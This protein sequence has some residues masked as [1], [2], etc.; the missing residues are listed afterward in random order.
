M[1]WLAILLAAVGS[2]S[3]ATLERE[4]AVTVACSNW[5]SGREPDSPAVHIV[6]DDGIC[7]YGSTSDANSSAFVD[8]VGG[9]DSDRPLVVVVRSS[10]GE[11]IAALAMAEAMVERT[12]TVVVQRSCFSSCA[13]Y[14]FLA[15]DRRVVM[16]EAL[17]GYHGGLYAPPEEYWTQTRA[18]F[19]TRMSDEEVEASMAASRSYIEDGLTRQ[20][21][22]LR[23]VGANPGFFDWMQTFNAK[24]KDEQ[25]ALCPVEGARLY[26]PSEVLLAEQGVVIHA[27]DGPKSDADLSRLLA[28]RGSDG[29]ICYWD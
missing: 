19:R 21:A 11:V 15:G 24:P 13:N 2:P 6:A 17:L 10:G 4:R 16:P 25:L 26:L 23:S 14:L 9:F 1:I 20:V 5:T 27:N 28:D 12:T 18:D 22:F 3:V 8:A 29:L 7:F